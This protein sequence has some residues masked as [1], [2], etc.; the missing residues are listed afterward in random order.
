[1]PGALRVLRGKRPPAGAPVAADGVPSMPRD[2]S[3]VERS[4]WRELVAELQTVPG[5]LARCDRGVL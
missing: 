1:M 2:L 5:L 3:R 4:A